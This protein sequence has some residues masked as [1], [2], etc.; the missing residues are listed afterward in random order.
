MRMFSRN[1]KRPQHAHWSGMVQTARWIWIRREALRLLQIPFEQ[2]LV[3]DTDLLAICKEFNTASNAFDACLYRGGS[4]RTP[5]DN[6]WRSEHQLA[7]HNFPVS[8]VRQV[9]FARAADCPLQNYNFVWH[10]LLMRRGKGVRK[11]VDAHFYFPMLRT[12][13]VLQEIHHM[14][15]VMCEHAG[16]DCPPL[17]HLLDRKYRH[18]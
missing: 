13:K 17:S 9:D 1:T 14:W 3:R 16:W 6:L 18:G 8:L 5:R 12:P 15:S 10:C 11:S 2:T 4:R 7:R